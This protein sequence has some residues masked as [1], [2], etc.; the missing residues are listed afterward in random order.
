MWGDYPACSPVNKK[1][2]LT[3]LPVSKAT[4]QKHDKQIGICL[5]IIVTIQEA[6]EDTA[7]TVGLIDCW[8]YLFILCMVIVDDFI[9]GKGIEKILQSSSYS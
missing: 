1:M 8:I 3:E 5:Q 2:G 6:E 7:V 9:S 4:A